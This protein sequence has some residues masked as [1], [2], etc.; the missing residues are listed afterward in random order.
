MNKGIK[1]LFIFISIVLIG[2]GVI[3]I[4]NSY[5]D[6]KKNN[7]IKADINKNIEE[8]VEN[9]NVVKNEIYVDFDNLKSINSDTVGYIEVKNTDIKYVVV[10]SNDNN[11]YLSY[12]FNKDENIAGWIFA[13]YR[14]KFDGTDKN[15]IIYGHNMINGSMFGTL[16]NVLNEE[17]YMNDDNLYIPLSTERENMMF[18]VFSIY[19]IEPEDY[20]I[21][22]EFYGN[23]FFSFINII[24]N[25]SIYNF[26]TAVSKNDTILTLSTCSD[27]G[28]ERI[29]VHAIRIS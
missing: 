6:S 28:L 17:W 23:E 18:K 13:D 12:D 15:I 4:V 16:K 27:S 20:Y 22:T 21:E 26:N 9:D 25:R 11:Y 5:K 14:N 29:V 8:P 3:N 10:K 1:L 2:Y 7:L 19:Q 24:K